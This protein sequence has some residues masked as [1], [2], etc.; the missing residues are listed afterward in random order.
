MNNNDIDYN[1]PTIYNNSILVGKIH[2]T[3][4][5]PFSHL[6]YH[7]SDKISPYLY[8]LNI[9]PNEITTVRF[10]VL[11][12]S[13]FY[14]IPNKYYREASILYILSYFGDCL[15]G[16]YSRKYNMVTEFG[17]YY[18][19]VIDNLGIV[20]TL[21]VLYKNTNNY[22][23][24]FIIIIAMISLIQIGCQ[25]KYISIKNKTDSKFLSFTQYLCP[26]C[27]VE[28]IESTMSITKLFGAGT[29]HIFIGLLIW[30]INKW[31]V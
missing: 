29:V 19:H 10:I 6:L 28:D 25:E 22:V 3:L 18:D 27:T 8:A 1:D 5:D 30:N 26:S 13:L 15:D 9:S 16:H 21:Y 11:L 7:I 31:H 12:V 4:E 14:C 2:H 20:L 23:I 24:I 17:D